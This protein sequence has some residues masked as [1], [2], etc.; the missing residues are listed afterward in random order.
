MRVG[1]LHNTR[2]AMRSGREAASN[3]PMIPPDS[4]GG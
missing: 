2:L 1:V 4:S 3:K